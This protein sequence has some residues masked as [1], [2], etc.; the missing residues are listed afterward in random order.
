MAYRVNENGGKDRNDQIVEILRAAGKP[1]HITLIA[2]ALSEINDSKVTRQ[3]I[4]PGLNRHIAKTKHLKIVK[5]GPSI[6]G[7]PE[8]KQNGSISNTMEL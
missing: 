8:W 4:E 1:L 6:F 3:L 2:A 5:M 7:L